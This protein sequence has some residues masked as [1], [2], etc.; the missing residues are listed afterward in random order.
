MG[1]GTTGLQETGWEGSSPHPGLPSFG[2][3]PPNFSVL[4]TACGYLCHS[5]CAPQAPPCPVPP[6]LLR[7]ALGV[8]PETGTGTAYEGFLSVSWGWGTRR[9]DVGAKDLCSSPCPPSLRYHGPQ[10][11]GGA[12]SGSMQPSVT[13]GYCC[14]M[15]LTH[16]PAQPVGPFCRPWI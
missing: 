2:L 4:P 7:T 11:S 9:M 8:H 14:L 16:G 5:A 10:A 3:T 1:S 6:D 15:P 13:H 12:G